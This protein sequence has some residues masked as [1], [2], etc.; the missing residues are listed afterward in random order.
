MVPMLAR[1][2]TKMMISEMTTRR[3]MQGHP[4]S[5]WLTGPHLMRVRFYAT[6]RV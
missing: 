2:G 1:R 3:A 4:M 6:M 5:T